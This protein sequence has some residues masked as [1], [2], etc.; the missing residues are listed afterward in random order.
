LVNVIEDLS[1]MNLQ[2]TVVKCAVGKYTAMSIDP[3]LCLGTCTGEI[4]VGEF[5]LKSTVLKT[6]G[7][8]A[9]GQ[10]SEGLIVC[11]G[12]ES[13]HLIV[14]DG[15]SGALLKSLW[16]YKSSVS[17]IHFYDDERIRFISTD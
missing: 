6:G 4:H 2:M 3:T 9:L 16:L 5:I 1:I 7:V 13:G 10:A 12:Y 11:G 15:M 8:T 14:W 17:T